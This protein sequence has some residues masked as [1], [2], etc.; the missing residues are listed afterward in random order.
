MKS[1][2]PTVAAFAALTL[3]TLATARTARADDQTPPPPAF[4]PAPTGGPFNVSGGAFGEANQFAFS[5]ASEGEFPFR[6]SKS[7]GGDWGLALR[8]SLDV[9]IKQNV[10]VGGMVVIESGGGSSKIGLGVRAGYN[11]FLASTVS[12]WLRG[13]LS[14][15]HTSVN[16][17]PSYSITTLHILVPFLF[18]F[19]PHFFLGVGPFFDQPLTDSRP[20]SGKDATYGL[21]AIVGGYF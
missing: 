7:G 4:S 9:F 5:M 18:H 12:L 11:I 21:T 20:G 6:L 16:N 13:G 17:G 8:P 14:Y 10:S 1:R 2:F 3:M 19:V 15:D